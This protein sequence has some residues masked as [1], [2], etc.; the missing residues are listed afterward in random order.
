MSFKNCAL[1][2]QIF[3]GGN[4]FIILENHEMINYR[5]FEKLC[6]NRKMFIILIFDTKN[7]SMGY[8]LCVNFCYENTIKYYKTSSY[9]FIS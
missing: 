8:Y 2:P 4:E 3:Y 6:K 9:S 7:L 5:N 1:Y